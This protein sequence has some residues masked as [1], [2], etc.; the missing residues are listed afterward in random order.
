MPYPPVGLIRCASIASGIVRQPPDAAYRLMQH[1]HRVFQ[2][3]GAVFHHRR[4]LRTL[5]HQLGIFLGDEVKLIHCTGQ[6]GKP[7]GLFQR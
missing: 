3:A 6:A 2:S 5:F 7:I 4:H 1:R